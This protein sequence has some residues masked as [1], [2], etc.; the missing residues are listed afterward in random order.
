MFNFLSLSYN[1]ILLLFSFLPDATYAATLLT[2]AK[3]LYEFARN[4]RGK[5][6]DSVNQ[7]AAYYR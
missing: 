6:S 3:Q 4:F 7:A 1:H 2:H 5:Y